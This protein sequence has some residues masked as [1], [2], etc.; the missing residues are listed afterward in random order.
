MLFFLLYFFAHSF[1]V[2]IEVFL[3]YNFWDKFPELLQCFLCER[4]FMVHPVYM[5]IYVYKN[6]EKYKTYLI[7]S[8]GIYIFTELFMNILYAYAKYEIGIFLIN[9]C[10][11]NNYYTWSR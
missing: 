6:H 10:V 5:C 7:L 1:L 4:T 3:F 8:K 9:I 2:C 11:Y